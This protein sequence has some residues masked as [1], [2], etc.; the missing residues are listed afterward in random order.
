MRVPFS[1]NPRQHFS[2][3]LDY[4]HSVLHKVESKVVLICIS[5]RFRDGEHFSCIYWPFVL[6]PFKYVHFIDWTFC[7]FGVSFLEF[8]FIFQI[9]FPVR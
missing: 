4:S 1:L 6:L 2:L 7:S 9:L 3:F 5:L 8:F